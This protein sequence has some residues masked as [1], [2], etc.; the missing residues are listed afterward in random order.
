MLKPTQMKHLLHKPDSF[1]EQ[2]V[3]SSWEVATGALVGGR[4]LPS[5][6]R[7]LD[8]NQSTTKRQ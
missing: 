1:S 5:M 7:G 2:E 6:F 4:G 3:I 8:S